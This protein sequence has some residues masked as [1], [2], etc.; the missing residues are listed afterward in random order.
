MEYQKKFR[1]WADFPGMDLELSREMALITSDE[2]EIAR[3]FYR[4][5]AFGTG[6]IRGRNLR[7]GDGVVDNIFSVE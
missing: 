3:R 6:G 4:D 2:E 5:I 7:I 1:H